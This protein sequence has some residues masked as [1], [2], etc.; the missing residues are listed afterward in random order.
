M[1]LDAY[2]KEQG[3]PLYDTGSYSFEDLFSDL[4]QQDYQAQV[5]FLRS[6][7][8]NPYSGPSSPY[9]GAV[10]GTVAQTDESRFE[11]MQ[12]GMLSSAGTQRPTPPAQQP[13]YTSKAPTPGMLTDLGFD[14]ASLLYSGDSELGNLFENYQ[15]PVTTQPQPN[16]G[17]AALDNLLGQLKEGSYVYGDAGAARDAGTISQEQFNEFVD[18]FNK[19]SGTLPGQRPYAVGD[20]VSGAYTPPAPYGTIPENFDQAGKEFT[21]A[22]WEWFKTHGGVDSN[23]NGRIDSDEY[24]A[25]KE[26]EAQTAAAATETTSSA[27]VGTTTPPGSRTYAGIPQE[28]LD[29]IDV[30]VEIPIPGPGNQMLPVIFGSVGEFID[31]VKSVGVDPTTGN[32]DDFMGTIGRAVGDVFTTAKDSITGAIK[33]ATTGA[34]QDIDQF[35]RDMILAGTFDPGAIFN[36]AKDKFPDVFG[37]TSSTTAPPTGPTGP[38]GPTDPDFGLPGNE[39]DKTKEDPETASD[40]VSTVDTTLPGYQDEPDFPEVIET[41]TNR[42]DKDNDDVVDTVSN[43]L[44]DYQDEPDF[45][46]EITKTPDDE[47]EPPPPPLEDDDEDEPPPPPLEDDDKDEPTP[48]P[49]E[50]DD[51]DEPTPPPP[52]DDDKDEPPPPPPEDDDEDEPPFINEDLRDDSTPQPPSSSQD[53]GM[54]AAAAAGAAFEPKWTELFKYTTLTPYQKKALAPYVDYIAQARQMRARGMLS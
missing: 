34:V 2:L 18:E 40:V 31:W 12:E 37:G 43:D 7:G 5:D 30:G 48:P 29:R 13:D 3:G 20:V 16:A 50:D 41:V 24:A 39:E 33:G 32:P 28:I 10:G 27:T 21:Q 44:L 51:E 49:L 23:N 25:Y 52:E 46:E 11:Q 35:I 22:D 54:M 19:Y 17:Q 15:Q 53:L 26:K 36:A 8:I 38:T 42:I 4:L 45:P 6:Q 14:P 9:I 1:S 47:D